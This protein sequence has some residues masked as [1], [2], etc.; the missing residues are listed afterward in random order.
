MTRLGCQMSVRSSAD[1]ED[2]EQ[3][4]GIVVAAQRDTTEIR[5]D[6]ERARDQLAVTVDLLADRL[7]P[8]R[9]ADKAKT[10]IKAKLTSPAGI[11]VAGGAAAVLTLV[12]V[13]NLRRSRR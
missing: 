5:A 12:V 1:R 7:A 4:K 10:A 9:L 8:Q 13:R 2:R 11:A 3:W 6:I